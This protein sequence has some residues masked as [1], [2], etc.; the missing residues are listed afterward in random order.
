MEK[1][2]YGIIIEA[3]Q[4]KKDLKMKPEELLDAQIA[5]MAKEASDYAAANPLYDLKKV[6]EA[7]ESRPPECSIGQALVAMLNNAYAVG[8]ISAKREGKK[9]IILFP[10]HQC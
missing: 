5:D 6:H 4:I 10:G 2:S 7:L 9:Q 1:R 8:Y 3:H